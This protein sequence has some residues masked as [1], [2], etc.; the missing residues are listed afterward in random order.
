MNK[1]PYDKNYFDYYGSLG[2]YDRSK[3]EWLLFFA[4]IA[5]G[6]KEKID[7]K[8][9]LE[10]GCA[11]GFLLEA[12]RDRGID[13]VGIDI[14][15]YAIS[16]VRS[17][18]KAYCSVR[19]AAEPFNDSYDLIVCMEVLE[20]LSE[21]EGCKVIK[22]IC[23]H[24]SDVIFSSNPSYDHPDPTHQNVRPK[25]YWI[26]RFAE[27]TFALDREFD[28][29]FIASHAMRFKKRVFDITFV[30]P[31]AGISGGGKVILE[32]CNRLD[33]VGHHINLVLLSNENINWFELNSRIRIIHSSYEPSNFNRDIPDADIIIATWWQTA[34]LVSQCSR[35][36]GRKFYLVQHYESAAF[37]T[38]EYTDY[39]Y[40][41]P[42][43]KI[44]VSSWLKTVIEDITGEKAELI[45]SGIDFLQFHPIENYRE[46]YPKL[47]IRIGMIYR[48]NKFK[49]FDDGLQAM[50]IVK[51]EYPEVKLT[52]MSSESVTQGVKYDE[53][54]KSPPQAEIKNF[55][56]SL[57][58]FVSPSRLEGFYLPGLEAMTCGIPV[59]ATDAGGNMD[60]AIHGQT[61][62]LSPASMPEL[63]AKNIITVIKDKKLA[64]ALRAN[65]LEIASRFTWDRSITNILRRS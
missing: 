51:K 16:H 40:W 34:P 49:G 38:P 41:L 24:A 17:D 48:A 6:I 53:L 62:L 11:K 14:S 19:T 2:L 39:T 8:K 50:E 56:N 35:E 57:D 9:V 18:I 32:Y 54:W 20:H 23:A 44:V 52:I 3:E 63:L 45:L 33:S 36:K 60:Y 27:N 12:L 55:Y 59:V 31:G 42:L 30:A 61:A 43:Q 47:D 21:E 37:S 65:A 1:N 25:E 22:N 64:Q 13:A 4:S 29:S 10:I 28:A 58:I 46:Q 5:D 7:P 26:R 15:D